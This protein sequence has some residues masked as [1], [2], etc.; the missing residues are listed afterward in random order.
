VPLKAFIEK[1]LTALALATL[2]AI[3]LGFWLVSRLF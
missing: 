1:H 3:G 2:G